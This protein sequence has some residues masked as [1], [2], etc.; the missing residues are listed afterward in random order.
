[1]SLYQCEECGCRENTALGSYW[2]QEEKL[3]SA[4]APSEF[5]DGSKNK[6]GGG[7]HGRFPRLFLPKGEFKTNKDG[8]LEH[9]ATGETDLS[10]FE[11]NQPSTKQR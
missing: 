8:N 11:I 4:C 9:I 5:S 6:R 1:M 3:C 2:M 10:K 7:W